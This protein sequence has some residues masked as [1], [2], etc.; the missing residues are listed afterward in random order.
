MVRRS[1]LMWL[2]GIF[3]LLDSYIGIFDE[4]FRREGANGLLSPRI[5]KRNATLTFFA[6]KMGEKRGTE[7]KPPGSDEPAGVDQKISTPRWSRHGGG[8]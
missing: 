3:N 5:S 2:R 8:R 6:R 1:H 7:R 4:I